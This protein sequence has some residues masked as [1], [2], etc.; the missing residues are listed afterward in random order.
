MKNQPKLKPASVRKKGPAPSAN[1][2]FPIVGIGASAGGLEAFTQLLQHLPVDTGMAFVLVQHLDPAHESALTGLLARTTAMPV[3]EVTNNLPVEPNHVYVIPPN[4]GM[5]L[6]RGKLKLL[7]RKQ[8]GGAYRSIDSFLESLAQDRHDQAIGVILSGTASDGTLGLEAIKA[9]SGITFAQDESAKYDSMPRSAIAAG[10][11]DFVLSPENIAGELARIARHPCVQGTRRLSPASSVESRGAQA[12]TGPP[13]NSA[14]HLR[15]RAAG[16]LP[17]RSPP[18]R[19]FFCC[20]ATTPGSISLS[21][22]PPPSS[23]ASP[24]AWCLNKSDIAGSL[25]RFSARQRD[26]NSTPSTPTCSSASPASSATRKPSKLSNARSF[27][28][29]L[30]P[31]R[32]DPVRVWVLGC[33]TGQ[34]A[35]SLAMAYLEFCENISRAPKLQIFA[36]DLNE[37]MLDK[38]RRGLYPKGLVQDVSP[39]RL[40]RFFVEEEGGYRV[41]KPLREICVFARQNLLTDPPFSRMDLV[42]CR[43][44][45]IY[46]QPAL[47]QKILP[48]FH[49]ALKPDGF[50]F[51]GAS[52][53]IGPFTDLFEPVDKKLKIF[54]RKPGTTPGISPASFPWPIRPTEKKPPR[55]SP[56]PRRPGDRAQR[57]ARSRPAHPGSLRSPRRARQCQPANPPVPRRHRSL[58]A[59]AHRQGQLRP[60]EDGARRLNAALA[61]RPQQGRKARP[62]RAAPRTCA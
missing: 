50:L 27:P 49:Y 39:E 16:S 17:A 18:S 25:R 38:A 46:I 28:S 33:S 14:S 53:S 59:A 4:A 30:Q 56:C 31:R 5:A 45:L 20:C 58:S 11:V 40:R 12:E 10:C 36:T 32:E 44:L 9:E 13:L 48:A 57:P 29:L 47:Q 23:G 52:E 35:Y 15:N 61:R 1:K 51:L 41:S 26:R 60:A 21:T 2:S 62:G 54:S 3:R 55:A 8:T 37:A 24:G 42:S 6:S 19:K 34:E 7:P 43:N 22:N